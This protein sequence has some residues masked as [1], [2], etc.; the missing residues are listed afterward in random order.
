MGKLEANVARLQL[1]KGE[2]EL[3]QGEV[4]GG[5]GE[6]ELGN[7]RSGFGKVI[8][9]GGKGSVIWKEKSEVVKVKRWSL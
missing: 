5:S 6:A 9:V 4:E 2:M 8:G 3:D 1:A 7:Y